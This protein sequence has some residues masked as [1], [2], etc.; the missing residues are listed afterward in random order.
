MPIVIGPGISIGPGVTITSGTVTTGLLAWFD[1]QSYSGSGSTWTALT[2]ANATLFNTPTYTSANPTYFSFAPASFQ[3]ASRTALSSQSNWTIEAWFRTT[4]TL[5]GQVTAVVTD[6]Y[7][8]NINFVMGTNNSPT[9]YNLCVGFFNGAWRTTTGFAPTL[10]TWTHC[11]GTYDGTTVIQYQ[12]GSSQST[13]TYTGTSASGGSSV[14]IARR[15]DSLAND[16]LNFFPGDIAV[17]RIY[18]TAL[19][20]TQVLQNYNAEKSR[21]GL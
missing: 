5:T 21:F 2:G 6:E 16:P 11:A 9:S 12:N 8:S 14:R 7:T 15:W 19:T 13:L 4:A 10:N 17:V 20:S 18:N 1:A 3:Y